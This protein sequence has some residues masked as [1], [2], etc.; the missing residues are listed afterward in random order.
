MTDLTVYQ[1]PES[2][3]FTHTLT[4]NVDNDKAFGVDPTTEKVIQPKCNNQK[5][6]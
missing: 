3:G 6:E 5:G 4:V 1:N 2:C